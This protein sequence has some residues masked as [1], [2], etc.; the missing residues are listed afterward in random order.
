MLAYRLA[1]SDR[2]INRLAEHGIYTHEDLQARGDLERLGFTALDAKRIRYAFLRGP[3]P[4]DE[5][6][7]KPQ[8]QVPAS[9]SADP[10]ARLPEL[11]TAREA[12]EFLRVNRRTIADWCLLGRLAAY[13]LDKDWRIPRD[14]VKALLV[15]VAAQN[16]SGSSSANL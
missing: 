3:R 5:Q 7:V 11:L 14:A 13:R 1:L 4:A 16:S 12:A 2:L 8:A 15:P 10:W 9:A 6:P